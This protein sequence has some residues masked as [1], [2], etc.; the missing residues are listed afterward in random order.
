MCSPLVEAEQDGFIC[1]EDLSKVVV[2]RRPLRQAQERLVPLVATAD[3]AYADDRPITF[4]EPITN[5]ADRANDARGTEEEKAHTSEW[6]AVAAGM[7]MPFVLLALCDREP[8]A[9]GSA[10][11]VMET[12]GVRRP[13]IRSIAWLDD[14]RCNRSPVLL[15][16]SSGMVGT[17]S[18]GVN[19]AP[20]GPTDRNK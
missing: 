9:A 7:V 14:Y 8:V 12:W 18:S 11:G 5:I 6:A 13:M 19:G 20:S 15:R 10:I 17:I 16:S 4:H 2:T 1:V 3:V